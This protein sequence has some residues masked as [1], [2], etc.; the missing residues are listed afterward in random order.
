MWAVA[1]RRGPPSVTRHSAVG[2]EITLS[3]SRDSTFVS[4]LESTGH[5]AECCSCPARMLDRAAASDTSHSLCSD[6]A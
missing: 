1:G 2:L 3:R 4:R 5:L 6:R